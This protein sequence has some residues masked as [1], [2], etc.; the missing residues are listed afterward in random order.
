MVALEARSTSVLRPVTATG[1]R[2]WSGGG[3]T[4][5]DRRS[6][7]KAEISP[8]KNMTSPL[9]RKIIASRTLSRTGRRGPGS[10]APP[11]PPPAGGGG[12]PAARPRPRPP[13]GA[14]GGAPPPPPGGGGGGGAGAAGG[15]GRRRAARGSCS[16]PADP[17][18]ERGNHE[19]ADDREQRAERLPVP[20][21]GHALS[22][23]SSASSAG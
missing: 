16:S 11:A 3:H 14:G 6:T 7:R 23:A 13:G 17:H 12:G 10:R 2:G 1:R 22:N 8:P 4:A 9:I 18:E 19:R 21:V 20:R 15:A 5:A